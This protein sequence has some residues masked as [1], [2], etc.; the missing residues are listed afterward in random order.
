LGLRYVVR[1]APNTNAPVLLLVDADE[2]A[3]LRTEA[4]LARRLGSDYSI[5][6][7]ATPEEGLAMLAQFRDQGQDVALVAADLHLPGMDGVEFLK[8]AHALHSHAT[9]LLLVA[10]DQYHTRVPF[11]QLP[12]L[13]RATALGQIDLWIVKGWVTPEEWLYPQLQEALT[14]WT[15][16]NRPH[17]AVYR[18]VGDQWSPRSHEI[19]D[20]FSRNGVPFE[21]YA[22]DTQE[23]R[24]LIRQFGIDVSR[25][26]AAVRHDGTVLQDPSDAELAF[27]HG[28]EVAASRTGYDVV[29][30]GAGPAGLAAA[31]NAASEGLA[32]V[33]IERE[34]IG[35][36]AGTSSLIRNYLGFQRGITGGE[37]AH[38]AWEQAI[39]FGAEFVFNSAQ[40]LR[41]PN[42]DRVITL[43]DRAE[44]HAPAVII[45]TGV[46]YRRLD[47]PGLDRLVGAGVFYGA[48]SV[49]APAMA[50]EDVYVVG[51]ANSAGQA[52]LHLA[53][54]AAHVALL[55]RGSSLRA[56]M[57]EYL[58]TQLEATP[59][60]EVRLQTRVV[61]GQGDSRLERITLEHV[62]RG[63]RE[64][65]PAAGLF[66]L[67]GAAPHTEWLRPLLAVDDHGFLL[68]G[69]NI[70]SGG[71]PLD[72]SPLPF[73]T[74]A[75]GVF[76]AGDVRHDSIKRVAAAVGEGSVTV[77]SV[78]QYLAQ[79]VA[80][81]R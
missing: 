70:P 16:A 9:R 53:K 68:T 52:A 10:M 28:I 18:F 76:A 8:R 42:G 21:F 31:V 4:A 73:E 65:V 33:V 55:V 71:W 51:G 39:F 44:V 15:L 61:E 50:G 63:A 36:Q 23:G 17:F 35:G 59:N 13:R 54:F 77:G 30:V 25:L 37:L 34:A 72:R 49:E 43:T 47:A 20:L 7:A 46:T 57:S 66:V 78:H 19:R 22:T 14:A 74:S 75:P 12:T 79:P 24:E 1:I 45:A 11:T 58:I 41:L 5:R 80:L 62:E 38:R 26:P 29:I 2:A 69:R 6:A 67:I 27:S 48:A 81:P 60:I 3:R 56:S 64:T 32:T 40:A